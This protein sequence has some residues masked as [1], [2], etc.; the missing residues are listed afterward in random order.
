[1]DSDM[2]YDLCTKNRSYRKERMGEGKATRARAKQG[3]A[4]HR[5]QFKSSITKNKTQKPEC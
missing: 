5:L 4:L 2:L 1:M 3:T